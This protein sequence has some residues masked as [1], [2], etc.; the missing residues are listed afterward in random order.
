MS[1]LLG[2]AAFWLL[3]GWAMDECERRAGM[4]DTTEDDE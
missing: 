3:G 1:F 2:I 4:D